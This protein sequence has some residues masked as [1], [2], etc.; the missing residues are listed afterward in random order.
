MKRVYFTLIFLCV[1]FSALFSQVPQGINYQAVVRD[2]SGNLQGNQT[3]SVRF[4]IEDGTTAVYQEL[5]NTTTNGF[6]LLKL[7]VGKGSPISGSFAS[8]SWSQGPYFLKVEIDD[9]SGFQSLGSTE[10][11]SV[12]FAL[13]AES[14]AG[15]ENIF[16]S[17]LED[18]GMQNPQTGQ[19]LKWDGS[20]WVPQNEEINDADSDPAN[21]LQSINLSG[22][23]LTLSNGGG[24]VVL[25]STPSY[26]GGNG[27]NINGSVIEN[28]GDLDPNNEIQTIS[29][30]GNNLTL[31][32]GGGSVAL[33]SAPTYTAGTGI[34]ISGNSIS[35]TGDLD[36]SDDV[37]L[38]SAAGGDLGG[39]IPIL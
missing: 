35:N 21:E 9:G 39:L 26:T 33:A 10:L 13:Y 19:V 22:N 17:D 7:L 15:V 6:G 36:G 31:S 12:P 23:N 18:V 28:T 5:H 14:A 4:S 25:P 3:V 30:S 34:S 24:S 16:L 38:G 32:N 8:V 37:L 29:L 2:A 11:V 20:S 1:S 27:I